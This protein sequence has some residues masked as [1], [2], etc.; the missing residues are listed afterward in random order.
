[1]LSLVSRIMIYIFQIL[2]DLKQL[3]KNRIVRYV[4]R[5]I[6]NKFLGNKVML[7]IICNNIRTPY[8]PLSVLHCI[9]NVTLINF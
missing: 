7:A 1:M 9:L 4:M 2:D 8:T 3:S 6:Y 5:P